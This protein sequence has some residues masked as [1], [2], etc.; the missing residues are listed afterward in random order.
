MTLES[1]NTSLASPLGFA[2]AK[3]V[4]VHLLIAY[5][6]SFTDVL[7]VLFLF[8][9]IFMKNLLLKHKISQP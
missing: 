5:I 8:Y 2:T 6:S 9:F 1:R 7:Q 3:N 4:N